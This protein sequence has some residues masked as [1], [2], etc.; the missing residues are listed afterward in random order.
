MNLN[1]IYDLQEKGKI[2]IIKGLIVPGASEPKNGKL[3]LD[4]SFNIG[5]H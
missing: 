3:L 1:P 2:G 5:I 4:G